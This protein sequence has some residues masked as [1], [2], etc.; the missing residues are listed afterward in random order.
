[1]SLNQNSS[2]FLNTQFFKKYDSN[3][4]LVSSNKYIR[5]TSGLSVLDKIL[6][7][8][9]M[10]T[11]QFK[12][13]KFPSILV[14]ENFQEGNFNNV[15]SVSCAK[16]KENYYP[17]KATMKDNHAYRLINN[18]QQFNQPPDFGNQVNKKIQNYYLKTNKW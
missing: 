16:L 3:Q 5:D 15:R 7:D 9:T 4:D 18:Q 12:N 2:A 13:E 10:Y 1:M 6:Y 11:S 8:T 14:N 17:F